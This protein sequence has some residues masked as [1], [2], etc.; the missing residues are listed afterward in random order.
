MTRLKLVLLFIII[1]CLPIFPVASQTMESLDNAAE[2]YNNGDYDNAI[3]FLE[4]TVSGGIN[5]GDIFYNLGNAY[6]EKGDIG[7][8][9]L[10]YRRAMQL[11]PRDLDLNIQMARTR[12]LQAIVQTDT[13]HWLIFIEQATETIITIM[14]LSIITFITWSLFWILLAFY[15]LYSAWR[16]ALRFPLGLMFTVVLTLSVL[17]G[18]RLYIYHN[19]PPAIV[20][21]DSAPV[22]SGPS[23][24]YFRQYDLFSGSEIYITDEQDEWLKFVTS[25]NQQGWIDINNITIIPL[26]KTGVP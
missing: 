26:N 11:I 2:A 15:R 22:Y 19:M 9:L 10:N 23:V 16:G 14:E 13:T 17:L 7:K 21:I 4:L 3:Q 20:T 8:A 12:S 1:G 24:S 5:N 6:Y 18:A 25:T